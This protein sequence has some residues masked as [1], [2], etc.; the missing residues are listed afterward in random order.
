GPTIV[1]LKQTEAGWTYGV[2]M[3]QLWSVSGGGDRPDVDALFF[4]PFLTKALGKGRT[5]ALNTEA[6]YDWTREQW[7]VPVNLGFSQ[8]SKLGAQLVS[9]QG[10]V[11]YYLEAPAGG[12]EWGLRITF[13]LLFPK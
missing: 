7:T 6:S 9:W 13:T 4:Q 2:L 3:N 12:P 11:R 5:L 10:G 1:A 8:V